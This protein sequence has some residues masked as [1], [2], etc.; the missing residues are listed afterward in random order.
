VHLRSFIVASSKNSWIFV[1]VIRSMKLR[2]V[3]FSNGSDL[4]LATTRG[5]L[6]TSRITVADFKAFCAARRH[7]VAQSGFSGFPS[8]V[9][10]SCCSELPKVQISYHVNTGC[11][12]IVSSSCLAE[13]R[14]IAFT[15]SQQ[16]HVLIQECHDIWTSHW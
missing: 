6:K 12:L 2:S 5:K 8:F 15:P 14:S 9:C 10:H 4:F 16:H 3:A 7:F 1:S 13:W 11:D